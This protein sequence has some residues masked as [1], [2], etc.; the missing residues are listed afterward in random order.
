M[1]HGEQKRGGGMQSQKQ[2]PDDA[3]A[4]TATAK[5]SGEATSSGSP[6]TATRRWAYGSER[7]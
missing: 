4:A 3:E 7:R 1:P 2:S 5:S 6:Q